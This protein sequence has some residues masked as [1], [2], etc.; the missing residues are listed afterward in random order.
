MRKIFIML[1]ILISFLLFYNY[2]YAGRVEEI[3]EENFLLKNTGSF[4][5]SNVAGKIMV[6][7]WDK[8]EV[9]MI[10]TKSISSW[11][12]GDPEELLDKIKIEITSKPESLR[13]NTHF[14][15]FSW[16]RN[17]RVDYEVWIPREVNVRL[18]SVS[19][20]IQMKSHL[21]RIFANTVSG[22]I[23]LDDIKGNV[24]VKTTS[25]NTIVNDVQGDFIW[26]STSGELDMANLVG[27]L[28]LHTVSGDISGSE[29]NGEIKANSVSGG[30][31][32][33]NSQGNLAYLRTTSGNIRAELEAINSTSD[34]SLS[35]ISGDIILYLP[36]DAAF[37]LDI[38]T[39]SGDINT[40]FEV[41]IDGSD[42]RKLQGT[43]GGGGINININTVSGDISLRKL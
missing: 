15:Q 5:L 4:S 11:G 39:I 10:A 31:N 20:I 25:G 7:S 9:K 22:K 14:P 13:I 24:E 29:V 37:Y 38:N 28:D 26:S 30:I 1:L 35:T 42:E 34:M 32:L 8:E 33:R 43:V 41:L 3:K 23:K 19:G 40:R 18:S 6:N 2:V 27:D 16:V 12:V 21:N 36:A 17:A